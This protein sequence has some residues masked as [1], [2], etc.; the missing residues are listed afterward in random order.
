MSSQTDFWLWLCSTQTA[1]PVI[2]TNMLVQINHSCLQCHPASRTGLH[3]D[4]SPC[5]DERSLAR[6]KTQT[7]C[8]WIMAKIHKH[9]ER[10]TDK[11]PR[12]CCSLVDPW[13][14]Q[15]W[16]VSS[17]NQESP[18]RSTKLVIC[19]YEQLWC[20]WSLSRLRFLALPYAALS[21]TTARQCV[22]FR[23]GPERA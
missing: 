4:D 6:Q 16:Q 17:Q 2:C 22:T 1:T 10:D 5:V 19:G 21:A 18:K 9:A 20:W 15:I 23:L 7:Q 14:I 8:T 13:S 11:Q 12:E 3:I